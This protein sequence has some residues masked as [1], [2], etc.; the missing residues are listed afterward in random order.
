MILSHQNTS[1]ISKRLCILMLFSNMKEPHWIPVFCNQAILNAII[2]KSGD[3]VNI[4]LKNKARDLKFC[5]STTILFNDE[6]YSFSWGNIETTSDNFCSTH[7]SKGVPIS[8]ITSFSHIFNAVSSVNT[9]PTLIFQSNLNVQVVKVQKLFGKQIFINITTHNDTSNG[10]HVCAQ[11]KV[12]IDIGLNIFH[13]KGGGYILHTYICDGIK[14]CPNDNSDEYFCTCN[15]ENI[16]AKKDNFCM[17][18]LTRLNR[19]QCTPNYFMEETGI[20]KKY[21][22]KKVI[23]RNELKQRKTLQKN[24]CDSG[25]TFDFSLFSNLVSDCE[26]QSEN[27]S[28]FLSLNVK[29]KTFQCHPWEI[30][31]MEGNML[32]FNITDICLYQLNEEHNLIPCRNGGHLE[33]CSD[34]EC[35]M[36]FKCPDY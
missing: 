19:T 32:C 5:K 25:E 21:E 30:H 35:N 23:H 13:C 36:R 6:C 15:N 24:V 10:N 7:K 18:W 29:G 2:C 31:C 16:S 12:A 33:N 22:L 28:I 34:F 8:K 20:C 3:K 4:I 1:Y 17:K 26:P 9:F 14:D 11:E 27:E